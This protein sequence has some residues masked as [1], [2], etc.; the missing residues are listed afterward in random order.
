MECT[1]CIDEYEFRHIDDRHR[2]PKVNFEKETRG[3]VILNILAL[4]FLFGTILLYYL[5]RKLHLK[6][7][8][9]VMM[10]VVTTSTIIVILL[11]IFHIPYTDYMK[12]GEWIDFWLGPAVVA[13]AYPLY[14]HWE[15]I[16][17]Y[18]KSLVIGTIFG[19]FGGI[20]SG[21]GLGLLFSL[22]RTE[23]MTLIPKS[24]T[25]P[26]ANELSFQ[27]GG[28]PSLTMVFVI[29]A[30]VFG[31][32]TGPALLKMFGV[33][34]PIGKGMGIGAGSHGIGTAKAFE[35]GEEEGVASSIAMTLCA[36]CSSFL[37]SIIALLIS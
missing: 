31:S 18:K 27:L 26:I 33:T 37:T 3:C 20:F 19:T 7:R 29:I 8:Y 9:S 25:S 6:F 2:Y 14:N 34:H 36:V 32:V 28:T 30:G 13:M 12:G 17:K 11:V 1:N 21:I 5:M 15:T 22:N 23:I 4:G 35:M 16:K 24:I 10:P